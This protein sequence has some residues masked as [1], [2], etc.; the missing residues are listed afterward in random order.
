[1]NNSLHFVRFSSRHRTPYR[2]V[3]YSQQKSIHTTLDHRKT[4]IRRRRRDAWCEMWFDGKFFLL[5]DQRAVICLIIQNLWQ[6]FGII[7]KNVVYGHSHSAS[8]IFH[9]TILRKFENAPWRFGGR[10]KLLLFL[11]AWNKSTHT[12]IRAARVLD[13]WLANVIECM[14]VGYNS[15]RWCSRCCRRHDSATI[16]WKLRSCRQ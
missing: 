5:T 4:K 1:M 16:L 8:S 11:L 15:V 13:N 14:A 3:Y 6:T 12:H 10:S 7:A 9:F 2:T